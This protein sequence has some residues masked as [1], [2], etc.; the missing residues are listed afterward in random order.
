LQRFAL[1]TRP[2]LSTAAIAFVAAFAAS[3]VGG[4]QEPAAP[5]APAAGDPA[6]AFTLPPGPGSSDFQA[7][8]TMCHTPDRIVSVRRTRIEWEEI[9]DKMVTRGAQ[10]T[11]S[12]YVPIEDYLL[13]NFG[14]ANVNRAPKDDMVLVFGLTPSEADTLIGY[15]KEHGP[16]ADFDALLTVPGVDT[17]KLKTKREAVTF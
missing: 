17:A 5:Q 1:R 2:A 9:L 10:I 16:I 8:C 6:A 14:K 4:A 11:D 3:T 12:N 7:T 15:R 13:R